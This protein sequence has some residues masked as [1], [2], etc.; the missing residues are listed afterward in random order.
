MTHDPGDNR[1]RRQRVILKPRRGEEAWRNR[2]RSRRPKR[3]EEL[4]CDPY[5][6][7]FDHVPWKVTEPE[8]TLEFGKC[9][10]VRS[11]EIWRRPDG[12]SSG[13]GS[14]LF[15]TYSAARRAMSQLSGR[16]IHGRS[17]YVSSYSPSVLSP[18]KKRVLAGEDEEWQKEEEEANT[19]PSTVHRVLFSNAALQTSEGFLRAQFETA[20]HVLTF[21][22]LRRADGSSLAK[23]RAEFVSEASAKRVIERFNDKL[24]DGN[25]LVVVMDKVDP[26]ESPQARVFFHNVLWSVTNMELKPKFEN[27]G[28]LRRFELRIKHDGRSLG[29]GWCEYMKV[30]D[31][32]VAVEKMNGSLVCGRSLFVSAYDPYNARKAF[33]RDMQRN[34]RNVAA[35]MDVKRDAA[36]MDVKKDVE[37]KEDVKKDV[38][39]KD[40]KTDA[41]V[42]DETE[43][44][45]QQRAKVDLS[46]PAVAA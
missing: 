22:L 29:M 26:D 31:A 2:S 6:C 4:D 5:R 13:K 1:K 46:V 19:M 38:E 8:L 7:F 39:M 27:I 34:G 18:L 42:K 14:C 24:V 16:Y 25:R 40:A 30:D 9:G 28:P 36:L 41:E 21:G 45:R 3:D 15:K 10:V 17:M 12:M 35:L 33:E 11:L 20:G 23:G 43:R 37:M 44:A 32:K